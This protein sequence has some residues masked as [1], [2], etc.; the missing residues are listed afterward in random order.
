MHP[1]NRNRRQNLAGKIPVAHGIHAVRGDAG[2]PQLARHRLAVQKNRRSRD[3]AGAERHRIHA[4][5][6]VAESTGVAVEHFDIGQKVVGKKDRLGALE[7][8]V[9]RHDGVA[10]TLGEADEFAL[11]AVNFLRER[12]AGFAQPE[13]KIERDLI[14]AAPRGVELRPGGADALGQLRLDVHVDIFEVHLELEASL[15]NLGEDLAQARLD[16]FKFLA[17]QDAGGFQRAGV[18]DAARD[19]VAVELPIG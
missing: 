12:F 13:S 4:G 3:G 1:E 16:F 15:F 8:R 10:V 19:V 5:A 2:K 17:G 7:V 18:G 11:Q 14:I 6:G 9:A